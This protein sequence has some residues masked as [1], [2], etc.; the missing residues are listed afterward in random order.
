MDRDHRRRPDDRGGKR[1]E[2]RSEGGPGH[3]GAMDGKIRM[4]VDYHPGRRYPIEPEPIQSP[5]KSLVEAL[6]G[7]WREFEN[8]V[9]VTLDTEKGTY[10][11]RRPNQPGAKYHCLRFEPSKGQEIRLY[12]DEMPIDAH[13]Y[14]DGHL[15]MTVDGKEYHFFYS[16]KDVDKRLCPKCYSRSKV[17]AKGC[18]VCGWR[19]VI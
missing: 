3:S 13:L 10:M 12:K 9:I 18:A 14:I 11:S 7:T 17:A 4:P 1:I 2:R 16:E 15:S 19:F 8:R 6:T 5:A